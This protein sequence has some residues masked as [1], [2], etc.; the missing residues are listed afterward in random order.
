AV[1]A[2]SKYKSSVSAAQ[3]SES[4]FKLMAQKYE[5][6]ISNATEYNEARTRWLMALSDQIQAKYEYLFRTKILDFY[7]GVPLSLD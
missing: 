3:S 4:S 6:G 1:A 2:E 5:T 7:K